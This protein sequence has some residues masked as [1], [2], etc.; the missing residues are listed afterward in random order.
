VDALDAYLWEES[1]QQG[2]AYVRVRVRNSDDYERLYKL[3]R[4][5]EDGSIEIPSPPKQQPLH[6]GVG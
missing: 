2:E 4:I 1:R 6:H 5:G 3:L